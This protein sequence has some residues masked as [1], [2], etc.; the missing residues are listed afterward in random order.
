M[1]RNIFTAPLARLIVAGHC[2]HCCVCS[3]TGAG[4]GRR[5]NEVSPL[6]DDAAVGDQ[7]R[8]KPGLDM[9]VNL[10]RTY[11]HYHALDRPPARWQRSDT[12]N[13]GA[14]LPRP[15]DRTFDNIWE[16]WLRGA[17][18]L[19]AKWNVW[20]R[21][22]EFKLETK[23]QDDWPGA[24]EQFAVFRPLW[25][26]RSRDRIRCNHS[27]LTL[28]KP[29]K[30]LRTE[31]VVEILSYQTDRLLG[32]FRAPP[33]VWRCFDT[34]A[35]GINA[36]RG[37][38]EA[39]VTFLQEAAF[40]YPQGVAP[41]TKVCGSMTFV[42]R[43]VT[44]FCPRLQT[45]LCS[46]CGMVGNVSNGSLSELAD[47]ALFDILTEQGDRK[48]F[49]SSSDLK[50]GLFDACPWCAASA[51]TAMRINNLHCIGPAGAL[52]FIDQGAT[53]V[54][55]GN[56]AMTDSI[57]LLQLPKKQ[58]EG[59]GLC[60]SPS[61]RDAVMA[62]GSPGEFSHQFSKLASTLKA[63][64]LAAVFD[65]EE[66]ERANEL[67]NF[68]SRGGVGFEERITGRFTQAYSYVQHCSPNLTNWYSA[69][70]KHGRS[71]SG[72]PS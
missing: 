63:E 44:P 62:V 21:F 12:V 1:V 27:T 25:T 18:L 43:G 30:L 46:G 38:K 36:S 66:Q 20:R 49:L 58:D 32:L 67:C 45:A 29:D 64:V 15:F 39:G 24:D 72:R 54:G 33:S 61:T 48:V 3:G 70:A 10:S 7:F 9:V 57:R 11:Y 47:L 34:S 16:P 6:L 4:F 60:V 5:Q 26:Q 22:W 35:F 52:V 19:G 42:I 13:L 8:V 40:H 23:E 69:L 14:V 59:L 56:T 17:K 53:F 71:S 31:A 50:S 55:V 41:P 2:W 37:L 51:D 65:P 28:C 68:D